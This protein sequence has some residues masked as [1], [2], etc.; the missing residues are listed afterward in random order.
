MYIYKC[1]IAFLIVISPFVFAEE[2]W[3]SVPRPEHV[4]HQLEEE[5]R[6]VW[7]VFA[8]SF[9]SERVLVRF[10]EDPVYRHVEGRFEA[11]ASHF[12]RGE[13]ALIVNKKT[14]AASILQNAVYELHYHDH[15]TGQWVFEKH[16]DTDEHQYVLRL[17]HP[18]QS[19]VLFRQFSDSFEIRK[20]NP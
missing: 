5:D 7:V 4:V 2:G 9:G 6:S 15:E 11:L 1:V 18:S 12:G 14:I 17:F 8:K 3:V 13:M 20:I 10:P 19:N 16:V